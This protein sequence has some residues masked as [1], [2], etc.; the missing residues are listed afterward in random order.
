VKIQVG[1]PATDSLHRRKT[2]KRLIGS[3][4]LFVGAPLRVMH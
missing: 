3:R 1:R 2:S 4:Y